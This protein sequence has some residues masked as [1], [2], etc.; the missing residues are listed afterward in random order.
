M[1]VLV[2]VLLARHGCCVLCGG[3][4][5]F[6]SA[7]FVVGLFVGKVLGGWNSQFTSVRAELV[8]YQLYSEVVSSEGAHRGNECCCKT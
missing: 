2:H 7:F 8:S 4:D 1:L 3:E 6:G 5:L